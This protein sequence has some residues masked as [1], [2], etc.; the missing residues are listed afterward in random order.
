[1][2]NGAGDG[3]SLPIDCFLPSETTIPR[4]VLRTFIFMAIPVLIVMFFVVFWIAATYKSAQTWMYCAKR[5]LLSYLVVIYLAYVTITKT[6]ANA[7]LCIHVY[8]SDDE[9]TLHWAMDTSIR[10]YQAS[11]AVLVGAFALPA[12]F[13][14]SFGF[15]VTL[16]IVLTRGRHP[17]ASMP[18]WLTEAT[19]FLYRAYDERLAFWESI[20]M[21]RKSLLA[22]TVASGSVLDG[23][24][25]GVM[26]I[27]VLTVALYVHTLFQPFKTEFGPLNLYEGAS[28]VVSQLTFASGILFNSDSVDETVRI[29]LTVFLG[30][31]ICTLSFFLLFKLIEA[32]VCYSYAF[33]E[34]EGVDI[35][36]KWGPCRVFG[37]FLTLKCREQFLYLSRQIAVMT[38]G[39]SGRGDAV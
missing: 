26:A 25:Q 31:M 9:T 18:S 15:P 39:S 22:A 32:I 29:L 37:K 12:L 38:K 3:L 27:C 4:S 11:H 14:V 5:I 20:V 34:V 6:A 16:A 24:V 33:L 2:G 30:L 21:L 35:P 10:C 17:Q 7:L 36:E 19:G 13:I 28:L 8:A 23:N 1:M